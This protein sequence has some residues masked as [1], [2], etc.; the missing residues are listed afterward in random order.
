MP[1]LVEHEGKL[2]EPT[3]ASGLNQNSA[4]QDSPLDALL[5]WT[6]L[7]VDKLPYTPQV[8][9]FASGDASDNQ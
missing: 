1:V 2:V 8:L 3:V 5:L 9:G 7:D 6:K 4:F